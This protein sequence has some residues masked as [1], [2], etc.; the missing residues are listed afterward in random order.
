[1]SGFTVHP[2]PLGPDHSDVRCVSA[3]CPWHL[4]VY[5]PA[6]GGRVLGDLRE[7]LREHVAA[8]SRRVVA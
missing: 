6:A 3:G 7:H 5:V 8:G 1:M 2:S 4:T